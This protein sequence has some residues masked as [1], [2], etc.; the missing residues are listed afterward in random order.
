MLND[1]VDAPNATPGTHHHKH[2]ED[3]DKGAPGPPEAARTYCAA[4][5]GPEDRSMITF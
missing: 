3:P 5:H 2:N 1:A 4:D